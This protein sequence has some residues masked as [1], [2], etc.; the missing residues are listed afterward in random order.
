MSNYKLLHLY[1]YISYVGT[2]KKDIMID[3]FYQQAQR[4]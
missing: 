3:H 2:K 1:S 4:K